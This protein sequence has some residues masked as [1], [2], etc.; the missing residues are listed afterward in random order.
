MQLNPLMPM[1]TLENTE[2]PAG[3][4]Y[5]ATA[6]CWQGNMPTNNARTFP[7]QSASM[8]VSEGPSIR[9]RI[10]RGPYC[11]RGGG[12][13]SRG[14]WQNAVTTRNDCNLHMCMGTATA[15]CGPLP[16]CRATAEV[17]SPM[18]Q[19][20]M[21]AQLD[22]VVCKQCIRPPMRQRGGLSLQDDYLAVCGRPTG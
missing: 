11:Y 18:S 21:C 2:K 10:G 13:F 22:P 16:P 12:G 3:S 20:S 14:A 17:H 19:Y 15:L 4:D 1:R 6:V 9:L 7:T 5:H 8:P